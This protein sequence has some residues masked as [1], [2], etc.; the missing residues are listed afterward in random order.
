[1]DL[2]ER[3]ELNNGFG[4]ALS[5]AVELALTPIIMG[6]LGYLLDGRLGTRPVFT[7]V[8]FVFTVGYLGWKQYVQYDA[9]MKEHERKLTGANR[10]ASP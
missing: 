9:A 7:I 4:N 1:V 5:L 8:L 2:R 6:F 3:R 10:E